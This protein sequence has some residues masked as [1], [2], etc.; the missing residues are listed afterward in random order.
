M[1][2]S[3]KSLPPEKKHK[4]IDL[5]KEFVDFITWSYE[6]LRSYDTS[7][8]Q[9]KIHIKEEH[10]PFKKKPSIINPKLMPLTEKEI[11]KMHDAKF[12]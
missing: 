6:D 4:Y 9:Q 2:K 7:I 10:K 12:P 1:I 11:N 8:I 3:S 5:F